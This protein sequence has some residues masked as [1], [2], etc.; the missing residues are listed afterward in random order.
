MT[1]PCILICEDETD[2]RQ[3]IA[4]EL[5][6]AGYRVLAAADGLAALAMLETDRPDLILCD[7]CMPRLDGRGL[8]ARLRARRP[9]LAD[10]PFLFLTA[11]ADRAEV[12]AGKL[13]GAD[14]YLVKPIDYD[15]MLATVAAHL[16]QVARLRASIGA[17]LA[18]TRAALAAPAGD[19]GAALDRLAPAIVLLCPRG[20]VVQANAAARAL[21][22]P[23]GPLVLGTR[24]VCTASGPAAAL[25]TAIAQVI[26]GHADSAGP[27]SIPRAD[28]GRDLIVLFGALDAGHPQGAAA[29][30][31]IVD[32]D[33]RHVP[34]PMLLAR[35]FGLTPTEARIAHLLATGQRPEDISRGLGVSGT[36]VAFHL[37]NLFSKTDT[38]RQSDLVA[39]I[40]SFPALVPL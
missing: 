5:S 40:L 26:S 12:V 19:Q 34:D 3:D 30:V 24:L 36:T 28:G 18:Q 17:R 25:R 9:D 10:V 22:G 20:E 16:R 37:K 32:P 21:C 8:L 38:N 7:I 14:D 13:A 2:L 29:L 31:V 1:P 15:L 11:L 39:L 23:A 27:V 4:A 6:E 35:V 33:R